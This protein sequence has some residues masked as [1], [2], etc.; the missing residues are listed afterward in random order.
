M[1][2]IYKNEDEG[3]GSR[4]TDLVGTIICAR[5]VNGHLEGEC[6]GRFRRR[7]IRI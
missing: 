7:G 1:Q 5:R 2:T 4:R 6:L 3:G